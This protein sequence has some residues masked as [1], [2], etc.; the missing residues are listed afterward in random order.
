[1]LL[2]HHT[3]KK[4]HPKHLNQI[5]LAK[6]LPSKKASSLRGCHVSWRWYAIWRSAPF[7]RKRYVRNWRHGGFRPNHGKSSWRRRRFVVVF[8]SGGKLL[9]NSRTKALL[10]SAEGWEEEGSSVCFSFLSTL[11]VEAETISQLRSFPKWSFSIRLEGWGSEGWRSR[12]NIFIL[13][14]Y[15]S[16]EIASFF[17]RWIWEKVS[18]SLFAR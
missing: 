16:L 8:F 6:L 5:L 1:M 17:F 14:Y 11:W 2:R 13:F 12:N 10:F 15:I 3:E 18:S 4:K 9:K 7:P